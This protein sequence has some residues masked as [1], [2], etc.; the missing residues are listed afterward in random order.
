MWSDY[1][2]L[3]VALDRTGDARHVLTRLVEKRSG[4]PLAFHALARF[5]A[6]TL[7]LT[8]KDR[9]DAVV[10]ATTANELCGYRRTFVL[11]T[12]AEAQFQAGDKTSALGTMAAVVKLMDGRDAQWLSLKQASEQLARYNK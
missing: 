6:T 5:L 2:A 8:P 10:H 12:L 7:G 3:L 1:G 11:A 4:D 9:K